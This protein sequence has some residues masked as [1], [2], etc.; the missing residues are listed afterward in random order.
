MVNG[1]FNLTLSA[2]CT[3]EFVLSDVVILPE[4]VTNILAYLKLCMDFSSSRQREFLGSRIHHL[5]RK[6][7]KGL[8]VT[9]RLSIFNP[10][11]TFWCKIFNVGMY[12]YV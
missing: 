2:K 12:M 10:D 5:S 3:G 1:Q 11:S 6:D 4:M 7:K 8:I 9:M